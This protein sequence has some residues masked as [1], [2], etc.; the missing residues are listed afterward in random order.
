DEIYT[1]RPFYGSRR[2]RHELKDEHGISI[3][4]HRIRRLMRLMGL[5]AVYP[6]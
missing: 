4:R 3:G 6:K 2:M 1:D 5:E